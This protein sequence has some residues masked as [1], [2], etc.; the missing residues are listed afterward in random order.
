M[1]SRPT[2]PFSSRILVWIIAAACVA[3][4]SAALSY[5]YYYTTTI[6]D[7]TTYFENIRAIERG[8]I[9]NIP[10]YEDYATPQRETKLRTF[11]FPAHIAV[12]ISSGMKPVAIDDSVPELVKNGTLTKIKSGPDRL[13]YFYNV[14]EKYRVL[15]PRTACGLSLIVERFQQNIA[16]RLKLPPVKIALSSLL[17]P[18][19]YQTGLRTTNFNATEVTTHSYGISFDVFY[20]DYFIALPRPAATNAISAALFDMIR[21]KMGFLLGDALR[22]QF[23]SVLMETLIQLQDEGVL[24]AILERNQHCYHVTIIPNPRCEKHGHI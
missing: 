1:E 10:I 20:D 14:R 16:T 3:A 23:R 7:V 22:S 18:A 17:R 8:Y 13:Y 2:I 24:Y 4:V 12:A 21:T 5:R 11:L 15:T 6:G 9:E 19:A